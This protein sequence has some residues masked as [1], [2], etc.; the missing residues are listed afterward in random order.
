MTKLTLYLSR[1]SWSWLPE[2]KALW[3]PCGLTVQ[4]VGGGLS[5]LIYGSTPRKLQENVFW[6]WCF[7]MDVGKNRKKVYQN[8]S[9]GSAKKMA[10]F[11]DG[12]DL[13]GNS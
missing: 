7:Q 10:D 2:E 5:G 12:C 13:I 9:I 6:L 8:L 4:G 1:I 11:Q 3:E